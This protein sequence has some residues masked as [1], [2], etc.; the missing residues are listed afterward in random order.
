MCSGQL[1]LC[2]HVLACHSRVKCICERRLDSVRIPHKEYVGNKTSEI[3]TYTSARKSDLPSPIDV[4]FLPETAI[5]TVNLACYWAICIRVCLDRRLVWAFDFIDFRWIS[6][7][8][9]KMSTLAW[10]ISCRRQWLRPLPRQCPKAYWRHASC[11]YL[12]ICS[13]RGASTRI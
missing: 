1:I 3:R 7:L 13:P 2:E 11:K 4:L 5:K 9:T 8:T 6:T 10:D 12:Y